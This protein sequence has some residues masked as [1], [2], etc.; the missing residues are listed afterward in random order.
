MKLLVETTKKIS[1]LTD[2]GESIGSSTPHVVADASFVERRIARKELR[3]IGTVSD[4]ATQDEFIEYLRASEGD[5]A[6]AVAAF[7]DAFSDN[8][9]SQTDPAETD[10]SADPAP[11]GSETTPPNP[12]LPPADAKGASKGK[13]KK[14]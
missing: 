9:A 8:A 2:M 13:G 5:R 4:E 1:L 14:E 6:L 3:I 12:A 11:P 10:A 7:L